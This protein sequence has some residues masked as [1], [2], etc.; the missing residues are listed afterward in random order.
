MAAGD[1]PNMNIK[2]RSGVQGMATKFD[3]KYSTKGM[4]Y[5]ADLMSEG[6]NPYG[7]NYVI[8]YI[9]VH[10]DSM[11]YK[12]NPE[13]FVSG[14][15][16][17]RLRG[18]AENLSTGAI[19]AAGVV[20]GSVA[21]N[22]AGVAQKVTKFTG[23]N[24]QEG[25]A[26]TVANVVGGAVAA[27]AVIT[28]VG[29]A[30]NEY[31]RQQKAIALHIPNEL[32]IKY[33]V[34]WEEEGTAGAAALASIAEGGGNLSKALSLNPL[35]A[36]GGAASA[37]AGAA[38]SAVSYGAGLALRTPGAGTL[39]SKTS[40]VAANPK[41]EQLFKQVDFR[42]F[43]FNYMFFPRSKDEAANI[44]NIINEFKLH[45]H[46][47]FKDANHFL[48]I[49]PSEF[50]VFYYQNGRE[51][52]NIH[53]HTSCVLTDMSVVYSPQGVFSSFDDGMP[54]QINVQ[55]TFK[56]LALLSK[57]SIKDGF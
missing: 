28:A 38:G 37:V 1:N 4:M 46:P 14:D 20:T 30:K 40:G 41:K 11:L 44:R 54:S 2:Y 15:V 48:Y 6:D 23:G 26:S 51:N 32:S 35:T 47:E 25:T 10:E 52:M 43:S 12:N 45:M 42:T 39:L 53:R 57:E 29:G 55:M 9:N 49:Y 5:P 22:T 27:G 21:A 17:P 19:A 36:L 16:P 31:K 8:F 56:E 18:E 3:N 33:G 50:D 7:G 34:S 13:A 24:L